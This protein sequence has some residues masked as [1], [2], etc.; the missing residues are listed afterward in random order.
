MKLN[1]KQPRVTVGMFVYNEEKYL[2]STIESVLEQDFTDYEIIISD[3]ASDDKTKDIALEY[4]KRDSRITYVRHSKNIGAIQNWNS[5]VTKA[6]GEY[7][8]PAGGHDLWSKNFLSSMV[9]AL[10]RDKNAVL[11]YAPTIWIDE[12]GNHLF[13]PTGF[14]DTSG[15]GAI[16]RFNMIIWGNQ[17]ALYGIYRLSALKKTRLSLQIIGAG[18]VLLGELAIIGSFIVVPGAIWYGRINRKVETRDECIDR[19]CKV[20]FPKPHRYLFPHWRLPIAFMAAAIRADL[21]FTKRVRLF[22]SAAI[23]SLLRYDYA[24]AHDVFA[25]LRSL[26]ITKK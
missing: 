25:I 26:F 16:A 20:L 15:S 22:I 13:K 18:A 14:I 8:V 21:P 11:A 3:N 19:Y 24:F 5:L 12:R 7:Y 2:S 23:N 6:R 4:T 1:N 9:N 17:F 10:D